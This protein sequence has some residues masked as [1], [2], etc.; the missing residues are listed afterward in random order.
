MNIQTNRKTATRFL[1]IFAI[2]YNLSL[3]PVAS[4]TD[5]TS[6]EYS[7]V[8][9]WSQETE[10][11]RPYYVRVPMGD[12]QGKWPVFV[13]LHGNGGNA[14]GSMNQSMKRYPTISS[15]YVMVF[16]EGYQKSWNIVSERSKAD[17]LG[18]V[19]A[20]IQH[21]ASYD[22]VQPNSFSI[23]GVSNGAALVNQLAIESQSPNIQNYVSS[24]SPLNL[25][26]HDGKF[27]RAKGEDNNYETPVIPETGK[28]LM[29]ISGTED[30]LVPYE[31]GPSNRI[32]AKDG[33]LAFVGAEESIYLWAKQMGY[34]GPKLKTP[35][36]I[37][38]NIEVFS[39]LNGDVI[40]Y[41]VLNEGHGATRAISEETLLSFLEGTD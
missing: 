40:H 2:F 25:Y 39:Y 24:V 19:E 34:K 7:V 21:L 38:D 30:R 8:Q 33:K 11:E 31:G 6:G 27:F 17:D 32:P 41:K 23:M 12:D 29:N 4:A 3:L 15:R 20:I 37:K 36:R 28:R 18:F 9:S 14:K 5:L 22:N 35:S 10:F 1:L 13:F 26:Q 16:A